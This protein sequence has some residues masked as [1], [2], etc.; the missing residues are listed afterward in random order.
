MCPGGCQGGR[1]GTYSNYVVLSGS[2]LFV[3]EMVD[4]QWKSFFRIWY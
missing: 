4:S 2:L 3:R 1:Q